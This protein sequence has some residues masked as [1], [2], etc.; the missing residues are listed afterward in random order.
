MSVSV[1]HTII[2]VRGHGIH[3]FEVNLGQVGEHVLVLWTDNGELHGHIAGI[4]LLLLDVFTA[5]VAPSD[6]A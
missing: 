6:H 4:L 5:R 2:V 1:V 3:R